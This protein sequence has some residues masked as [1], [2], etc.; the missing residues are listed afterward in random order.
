MIIITS[1]TLN[2]R[3]TVASLAET[4]VNRKSELTGKIRFITVH[5]PPGVSSLVDV[6]VYCNSVQIIPDKGFLALDSATPIFEPSHDISSGDTVSVYIGNAD[7]T[8]EHTIS[9]VVEI[10][11]ERGK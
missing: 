9:V 3:E 2:F 7:D 11:G 8:N 10:I 4:T 6:A 5:F 1:Q